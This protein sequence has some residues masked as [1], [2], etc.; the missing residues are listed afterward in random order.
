MVNTH[1][2]KDNTKSRA[3][4]AE[5]ARCRCKMCYRYRVSRVCI[6]GSCLFRLIPGMSH[7]YVTSL[8]IFEVF[9]TYVTTIFQRYNTGTEF[10]GPTDGQKDGRTTCHSSVMHLAVKTGSTG[11][12]WNRNLGFPELIIDE[13][14]HQV[15][16]LF[17]LKLALV[18]R[19]ISL[20]SCRKGQSQVK[21]TFDL[22]PLWP[23]LQ[24]GPDI[25]SRWRNVL[26]QT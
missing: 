26:Q 18:L 21:L 11:R 4:V 10:I 20:F 24:L 8:R 3:I 5:T 23:R 13:N 19:Q 14:G 12:N 22:W 6:A 15:T 17:G 7:N 1:R 25:Q 9:Q 16:V 2:L